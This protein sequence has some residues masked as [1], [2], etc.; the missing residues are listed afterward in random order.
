MRG[1]L[2][3][4]SSRQGESSDSATM[5]YTSTFRWKPKIRSRGVGRFGQLLNRDLV[6]YDFCFLV[7]SAAG[8]FPFELQT[9]VASVT[10][11]VD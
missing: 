11:T 9:T 8:Q 4:T 3:E 5:V 7:V 1:R 6:A 2:S 10:Q